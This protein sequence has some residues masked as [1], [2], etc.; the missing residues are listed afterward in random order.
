MSTRCRKSAK[1]CDI[2]TLHYIASSV[3]KCDERLCSAPTHGTSTVNQELFP[4][5]NHTYFAILVR[6]ANH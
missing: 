3:N 2:I 4:L 5:S 1:Q 6:I